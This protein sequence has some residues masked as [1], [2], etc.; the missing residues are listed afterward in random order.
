MDISEVAK[1]T[2][3]PAS[4][5]RY[6]EDKGLIKS[7]G[8]NGLRRIFNSKVVERLALISLGRSVDFSLDEIGAM[9]T[10][11]GVEINRALLLMKADE[12]DGKIKELTAMRDGL[13]HA[14]VCSA[15]NHFECPKF[16][17]LLKVANRNRFRQSSKFKK[18]SEDISKTKTL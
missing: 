5:I 9:F 1:V 6:Y 15:S 3:L 13:R 18:N 11:E 4:T 7:I 12:L 17:R 10:Q 8:R 16:L 14:A 2:R